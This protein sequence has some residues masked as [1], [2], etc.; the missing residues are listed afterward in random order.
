MAF[1]VLVISS[2]NLRRRRSGGRDFEGEIDRRS[3]TRPLFLLPGN[4]DPLTSRSIWDAAHPFRRAL[5][6]YVKVVDRND[7]VFEFADRAVLY[8]VPCQ[9]HA[10]QGDPTEDIPH[11][12]PGDERIRIGMVHGQTF[13]IE[14]HQ[15]NFPIAGDAADKRGLDYLALGDT[16]S[17]REI[18]GDAGVPTIYPGAPEATSFD[19]KGRRQRCSD[20]LPPRP[21]PQSDGR[22]PTRRHLDLA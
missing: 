19:E 18:D 11:R 3:W 20:L 4:H 7:F 13:D 22:T 10:G 14:G 5:P 2:K 1:S 12:E 9:S 17:F 21:R 6:S 15:T 8:A 16:H